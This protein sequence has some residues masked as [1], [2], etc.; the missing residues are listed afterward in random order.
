MTPSGGR[1]GPLQPS[2]EAVRAVLHISTRSALI[3]NWQNGSWRP[4]FLLPGEAP[5]QIAEVTAAALKQA[6]HS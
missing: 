3:P 2:P 6:S 1:S 4:A 5:R